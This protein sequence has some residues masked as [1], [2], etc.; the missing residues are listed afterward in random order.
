MHVVEAGALTGQV[1]SLGIA[2]PRDVYSLS[3][4]ALP[5]PP[6]DGLYGSS[7]DPKE[8]FG[9][10]LGA[11]AVHGEVGVLIVSLDL[12]ARITWNPFFQYMLGRI[13]EGIAPH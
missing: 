10:N 5:F 4:V 11:V 3:H 8:D 1:R 6:T 7:P 12:L 13:E 9:V 2:Y